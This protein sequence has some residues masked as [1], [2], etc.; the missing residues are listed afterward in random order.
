MPLT[1]LLTEPHGGHKLASH[2]IGFCDLSIL[3]LAFPVKA[4]ELCIQ[5]ADVLEVEE[6]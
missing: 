6:G 1:R 2:S 3:L 5:S 4:I